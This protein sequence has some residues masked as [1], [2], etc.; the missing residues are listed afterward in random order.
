MLSKDLDPDVVLVDGSA[1]RPRCVV[2][3]ELQRAKDPEKFRQWPRYAALKWLR[4]GCP[5]HLLVICPDK[6]TADWYARPIPTTLHEYTHWPIILRS[7]HVP[8]LTDGN[9]QVPIPR[10]E[11]CP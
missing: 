2:I 9:R 3:V 10:W 5:I 4:Y 1:E 8:D 7:T 6:E 11:S